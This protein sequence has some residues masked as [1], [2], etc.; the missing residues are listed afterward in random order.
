MIVGFI[1]MI[2]VYKLLL[3]PTLWGVFTTA[4]KN[5]WWAL[6]PFY[7]EYLWNRILKV[8]TLQHFIFLFIPFIN[9]F[10]FWLLCVET[11]YGYS[12]RRI[13]ECLFS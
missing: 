4:G 3:V 5:P 8:K 12:R 7:G 11:T 1:L 2:V 9:V 6:V 10:V 13:W